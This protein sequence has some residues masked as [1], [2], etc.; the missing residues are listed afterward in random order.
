MAEKVAPDPLIIRTFDLGGDKVASGVADVVDEMN[1]FLGWR[2]VRFC[3][4]NIDMF[5]A[6]LRAIL[7][8]LA[9]VWR[10]SRS[11]SR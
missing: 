6:Q 10:I 2:A 1:P 9:W 11:C 8:A 3:L 4:D 7:R 5:K